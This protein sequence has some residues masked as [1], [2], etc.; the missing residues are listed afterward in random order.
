MNAPAKE[1]YVLAVDLGTSGPKVAL[2]NLQGEIVTRDFEPTELI[3]LPEGGAEQDPAAWWQAVKKAIQRMLRGEPVRRKD[4]IAIGCTAQWSGTVALDRNG[5]PLMNALIWMDS[6][7]AAQI[8]RLTGG[9]LTVSGYGIHQLPFWLRL[10][11]GI[12]A[13]SGKDSLAHILFI[14][15]ERPEIF[16][17]TVK[18]LE[19]KDYLNYLF[20]G[21]MVAT[22][23]SITLHWL[24]DNR[25]PW[26]IDYSPWLLRRC[27]LERGLFPDLINATDIVGPL[28]S[29]VATELGLPPDVL[30]VG[31]SPDMQ[32]AII[33]SGAIADFAG[34]LY[35]GT[36]SWLITHVPFKKTDL[37]HNMASLPAA[38]PGRYF[39][40]NEQET[41]GACLNHLINIMFGGD[42]GAEGRDK[43]NAYETMEKLAVRAPPGS[44]R[45]IYTPWLYGERTPVEDPFIRGGFFNM[46]LQSSREHLARAVLEG[47]AL[48]S[49]RLLL[50]VEKFT[51]RRMDEIRFIGGG[52]ESILWSNIMA[53]VLNRRVLRMRDPRMANLRGAALLALLALGKT[54][55]EKMDSLVPVESIHE[56]DQR[57]HAVYV[58]LFREF[59]NIYKR[60]RGI[61]ARLN[62]RRERR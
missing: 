44:D 40:A 5:L 46:S 17:Q 60:T 25:N 24:T 27:G 16:R 9:P 23:D 55:P 18:F 59:V 56:P 45:L 39:L 54:T 52:A 3:L 12:P 42:P 32:T 14:R 28:R 20:T 61:H 13:Q 31:G 29:T 22:H 19:P 8:R 57:N 11:G 41:A 53:D 37:I 10:T 34:H 48:N 15:E 1:K 30:V 36:S 62:R 43:S 51:G 26:Q 33:G 47:V 6:R 50:A 4:I 35:L 49:R 58:E 38:L 7:G 2:V 21:R